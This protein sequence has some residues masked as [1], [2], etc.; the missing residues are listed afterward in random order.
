MKRWDFGHL[1]SVA[2]FKILH[3][4][5]V[6]AD[7]ISVVIRGQRPLGGTLYWRSERGQG[8]KAKGD[9]GPGLATH[10]ALS[11][12]RWEMGIEKT[13][14]RERLECEG[15]S[16]QIWNHG[17]SLSCIHP[18]PALYLSHLSLSL[19]HTDYF[20]VWSPC[21]FPND[22]K[23]DFISCWGEGG[24][25]IVVGQTRMLVVWER[26]EEGR[27]RGE[28]VREIKRERASFSWIWGFELC[29]QAST[30]RSIQLQ[31]SF[32][33]TDPGRLLWHHSYFFLAVAFFEEEE[34]ETR[35]AGFNIPLLHL[36]CKITLYSSPKKDKPVIIYSP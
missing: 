16:R 12:F 21:G 6:R 35:I 32:P 10:C 13:E 3:Q 11:S 7:L 22:F 24:L 25:A 15:E 18:Q 31:C 20:L 36:V 14:G 28:D 2:A 34:E 4:R 26:D 19:S 8:G 5:N 30:P 17:A 9:P 1:T 33:L 27:W 23:M 29:P